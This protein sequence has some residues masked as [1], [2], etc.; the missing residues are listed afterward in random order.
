MKKGEEGDRMYVLIKGRLGIYI[1]DSPKDLMG[2][3]IAVI[4]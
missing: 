3:P 4:D 2:D 1:N